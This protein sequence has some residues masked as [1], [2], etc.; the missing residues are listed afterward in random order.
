M[1]DIDPM[2]I[3]WYGIGIVIIL[4]F[5]LWGA[6]VLERRM[7]WFLQSL[8]N[9]DGVDR[10]AVRRVWKEIEKMGSSSNEHELRQAVVK[11]DSLLD[12]VLKKKEMQGADMAR[13]I[14]FAMHRFPELRLIWRSHH[15]R[16]QI[17]HEHDQVFK[18]SQL[19]G[20][21]KDYKKVLR[22]L[23]AI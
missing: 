11:A 9:T 23:G 22:I 2:K 12:D 21:L 5:L 16:N 10:E 7:R 14:K 3:L 15:L 19:R 6:I 1:L 18:A 8:W 4:G 13:R 20:A 17:V